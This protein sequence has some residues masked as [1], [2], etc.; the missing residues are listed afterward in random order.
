MASAENW[1]WPFASFMDQA[2]NM[3]PIKLT[4]EVRDEES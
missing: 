4:V 3:D 2:I 1:V